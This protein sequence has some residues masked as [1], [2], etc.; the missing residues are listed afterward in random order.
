[1]LTGFSGDRHRHSRTASGWEIRRRGELTQERM[2]RGILPHAKFGRFRGGLLNWPRSSAE[3]AE[4]GYLRKVCCQS[5]GA[6]FA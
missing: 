4:T 2:G 6:G 3:S 1:M 5:L